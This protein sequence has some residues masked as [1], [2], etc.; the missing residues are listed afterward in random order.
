MRR[1]AQDHSL[2]EAMAL[3]MDEALR[4]SPDLVSQ[5]GMWG[6]S[7]GLDGDR[8][9]RADPTPLSQ[10]CNGKKLC[11][12]PGASTSR[13]GRVCW[14]LLF[15][16]ITRVRLRPPHI[17]SW[18][19]GKKF[20]IGTQP[21]LVRAASECRQSLYCRCD[22]EIRQLAF[23]V[24]C[25]ERQGTGYDW[26]ADVRFHDPMVDPMPLAPSMK[27][28]NIYGVGIETERYVAWPS[29]PEPDQLGPQ[30]ALLS[31]HCNTGSETWLVYLTQPVGGY[32][33]AR[34]I[35]EGV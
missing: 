28:V 11:A 25:Y 12:S 27:M 24:S 35:N 33:P 16:A 15:C 3:L 26:Q 6:A 18:H 20:S 30:C 21:A 19:T 29:L 31:D 7:Y 13:S 4:T 17:A 23:H 9:V 34:C 5:L 32:P 14:H 10:S 1:A 22:I 2:N 8:I